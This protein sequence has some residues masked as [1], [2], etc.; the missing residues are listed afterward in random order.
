MSESEYYA[1]EFADADSDTLADAGEYYL[2]DAG[3]YEMPTQREIE[4]MRQG[5]EALLFIDWFRTI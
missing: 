1:S 2:E 4:E 5:G 3:F